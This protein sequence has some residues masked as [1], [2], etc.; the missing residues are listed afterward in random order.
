MA[1]ERKCNGKGVKKR[2]ERNQVEKG[3]NIFQIN[4]SVCLSIKSDD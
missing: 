4:L 2:E 1:I 3:S